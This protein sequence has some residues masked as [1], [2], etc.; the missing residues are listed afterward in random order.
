MPPGMDM[1]ALAGMFGGGA[2]GGAAGAGGF[3]PAGL[4]A[5]LAG[6]GGGA[7]GGMG[8]TPVLNPEV[9]FA[10]QL[11]Q[12]QVSEECQRVIRDIT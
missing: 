7:G 9:A 6:M 4:Q 11:G 12:L 1:S 3:D 5:L 10:S 2:G 8:H